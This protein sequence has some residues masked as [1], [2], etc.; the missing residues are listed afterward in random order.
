MTPFWPR[1]GPQVRRF[2]LFH[3]KWHHVHKRMLPTKFG[4][5]LTI[6]IFWPI[7]APPSG[8][9][10]WRILFLWTNFVDFVPE[11]LNTK[12]EANLNNGSWEEDFLTCTHFY[13]FFA[14][15]RT[16]RADNSIIFTNLKWLPMM[17]LSI[18]FGWN[19]PSGS[20]EEVI[21][22]KSLR[23]DGRTDGRTTDDRRRTKADAYSSLE[24]SAQVS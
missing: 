18:K 16:S 9:D 15:Y 19:R 23:T 20:W 8:A 3:W 22:R 2:T 6:L 13:P 5:N 21:L 7:S 1:M 11:S 4:W 10:Y 17:M 12:Y 14:P 24:L